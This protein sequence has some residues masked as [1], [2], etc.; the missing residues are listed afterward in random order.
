MHLKIV[1]EYL[2]QLTEVRSIRQCLYTAALSWCLSNMGYYPP[3]A[4]SIKALS[5]GRLSLFD[6]SSPELFNQ[7]KNLKKHF[8]TK[9]LFRSIIFNQIFFYHNFFSTSTRHFSNSR[10]FLTSER[11]IKLIDSGMTDYPF[12][13]ASPFDIKL[14]PRPI[15]YHLGWLNKSDNHPSRHLSTV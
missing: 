7:K 14:G 3:L 9:N 5:Q 1:A 11:I 6:N 2:L 10:F 8:L 4:F 12:Y 15:G 13:S